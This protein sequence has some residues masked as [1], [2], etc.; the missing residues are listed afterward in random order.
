MNVCRAIE[1]HLLDSSPAVQDAAIELISKYMI[2]S[3]EVM[4]NYYSKIT[5]WIVVHVYL[6]D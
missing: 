5:D 3:P 2:E 1:S 4:G 6:W